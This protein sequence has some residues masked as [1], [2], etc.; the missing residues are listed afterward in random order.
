MSKKSEGSFLQELKEANTTNGKQQLQKV[1][2]F[3]MDSPGVYIVRLLPSFSPDTRVPF[4][5]YGLHYRKDPNFPEST[6]QSP[7]L[8]LG[9]RD[10]ALC[11]EAYDTVREEKKH[12]VDK[13]N[14]TAWKL[15]ARQMAHYYVMNDKDELFYMSAP[16]N[17]QYK[18]GLHDEIMDLAEKLLNE[19]VNIFDIDDGR[20]LQIE[21]RI[22]DGKKKWT[23]TAEY[24]S[25]SVP[26]SI[27]DQMSSVKPLNKMYWRHKPEQLQN[28]VDGVPW[29]EVKGQQD[30]V[31]PKR[32]IPESKPVARESLFAKD[33]DVEVSDSPEVDADTDALR[34]EIFGKKKA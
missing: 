33:D 22:I 16:K 7:F 23:I 31:A 4:S 3:D 24:N 6:K 30:V 20:V 19:D 32:N 27:R 8:C 11:S 17:D 14:R 9:G 21:L 15:F 18:N 10:C 26:Q 34:E 12:A 29:R 1:P 2:R 28:V 5:L 13:N 25:H